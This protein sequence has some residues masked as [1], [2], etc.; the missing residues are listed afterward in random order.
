MLKAICKSM[1][2]IIFFNF[3]GNIYNLNICKKR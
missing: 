3:K 2:D 1:T